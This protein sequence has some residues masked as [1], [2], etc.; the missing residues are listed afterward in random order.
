MAN[1]FVSLLEAVGKFFEKGLTFAVKYLPVA[2]TLVES[3]FPP[4]VAVLGPATAVADLLQNSIVLVEQKYAAS[5]V[6]NGTGA[7]KAAEVLALTEQAVTLMLADP[8][9]AKE[10]KSAG[11]TVDQTYIG[12]LISGVVGIL[13]VKGV[14]SVPSPTPV[15]PATT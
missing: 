4:S 5:G 15:A 9:V 7:Q 13:N 2:D 11:I 6:Q 3:L 8:T 10:L 12:N 1:K 14:S